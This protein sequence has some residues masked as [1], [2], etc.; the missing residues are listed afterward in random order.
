MVEIGILKSERIEL[1]VNGEYFIEEIN[2]KIHEK[3]FAVFQKGAIK[4]KNNKK[5]FKKLTFVPRKYNTSLIQISNVII[6][7]NFH[8]QRSESQIFQG[9]LIL[10]SCSDGI[11]V[12]NRLYVEDYLKSV[13]SSEMKATS[14]KELLKAHA[15]ISR[16]WLM[17]QM[18]RRKSGTQKQQN[19]S[20]YL[21]N[22]NEIIKWYDSNDHKNFDVCADDHC[23]RYQG[24]SRIE[25]VVVEAVN[26]TEGELIMYDNKICDARF[27]KSCGG[28]SESF[29]NVWE[30][31]KIPY[32]SKIID[33]DIIPKNIVDLRN[34]KNA[35]NHILSSPTA[36]CNTNKKNVL[37][38]I[39]NEYDIGTNF[40][41]WRVEY[42][43]SELSKLIKNKSGIDFGEIISMKPIERGESAR[44]VRLE[45]IGKKEK[46]IIG[47]ELEI[48]RILSESH[49]NSSAFVV[50]TYN[51]IKNVPQKFVLKGAGWGHGVGLCQIGAAVMANKS[52]NYKQILLH[53]FKGAEIVRLKK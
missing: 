39:L 4:L 16:S 25:N 29:E 24:V 49:L 47:K 20:T 9:T 40:F 41:R 37:N 11:I 3:Q 46:K 15:V 27:S 32:L 48:R 28:V 14:H 13:I 8:W 33:S 12:I 7:I 50:E 2:T 21:D 45:I 18:E 36:F 23:Q 34:E 51:K 10:K 26:E 22:K 6:G 42:S 52:Y 53:Y 38:Q 43:Q 17:A 44:I 30:N 5:L 1:S 35:K 31:T 19:S